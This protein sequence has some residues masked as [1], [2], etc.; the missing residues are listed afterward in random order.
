MKVSLWGSIVEFFT[1]RMFVTDKHGHIIF[2]PWGS[3]R[4]GFILDNKEI[5]QRT[6]NFYTGLAIAFFLIVAMFTN[7]RIA[8]GF[9]CKLSQV[10]P[11]HLD[12]RLT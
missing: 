12:L 8:Q 9:F 11:C 10:F 7:S 5:K 6:A 4:K 1:S 3:K 2:F